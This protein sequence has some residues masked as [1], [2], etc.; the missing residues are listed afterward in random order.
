MVGTPTDEQRK[1]QD[2][3]TEITMMTAAQVRPGLKSSELSR[4]CVDLAASKGIDFSFN[5]GRLGHGMGINSTEPPHIAL[6]DDTILE[7]GMVFT[8]EPGVVNDIGTFIVEENLVVRPDGYELLTST[9][10]GLYTI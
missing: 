9:A 3:I 6:Y 10:R 2:V 1:I 7:P 5:C 8:L 4:Y